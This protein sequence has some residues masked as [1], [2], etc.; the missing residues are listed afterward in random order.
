MRQLVLTE[1]GDPPEGLP[2]LVTLKGLLGSVSSRVGSEAGTAQGSR[3][4]GAPRSMHAL[5]LGQGG[6]LA[7]GLPALPAQVGPLPGVRPLVS[8]QLGLLAEGLPALPAAVGSLPCVDPLVM[9]EAGA[10]AKGLPT[11]VTPVGLLPRV[12]ALMLNEF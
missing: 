6:A 1:A 12:R 9:D 7:E 2:T 4:R 5:V 10:L 3:D 11:L 8:D